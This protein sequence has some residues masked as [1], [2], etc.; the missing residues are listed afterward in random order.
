M[1]R[2]A[3]PPGSKV[4]TD[5]LAKS[6]LLQDLDA[7]GFN[8]V[9]YGCTTCIGNSG[10]L[11]PEIEQQIRDRNLYAV[12]VLSGNRNFDGRIHPLAKASF[13]MSPMLVVAYALVGRIEFDFYK[14]PIGKGSDGR[15]IFLKDIWPTM[16]EIR[17]TI[18]NSLSPEFY[19]ETYG[20]AL[21]GDDK[22]KTL[23]S[24]EGDAYAWDEKST[25]IR[26]PTWFVNQKETVADISNARA[27]DFRR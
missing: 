6:G 10:P 7:L 1:S 18:S 14:E 12:A 9:G 23:Q 8:I 5:Y 27:C 26:E 24:P 16:K 3:S 22:W 19:K 21:E 11:A 20:A 2:E 15:K 13:L 17:E 4:V 25:Y